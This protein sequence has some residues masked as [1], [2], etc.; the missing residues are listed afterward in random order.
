MRILR[1]VACRGPPF[2]DR[3]AMSVTNVSRSLAHQIGLAPNLQAVWLHYALQCVTVQPVGATDRVVLISFVIVLPVGAC[4][5]GPR[6][7][8]NA[9]RSNAAAT[10][11]GYIPL[12]AGSLSSLYCRSTVIITLLSFDFTVV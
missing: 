6:N 12:A 11:A 7:I 4:G 10:G 9:R 2:A 3:V 1:S 5:H 8:K